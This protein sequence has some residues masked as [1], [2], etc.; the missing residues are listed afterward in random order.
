VE[1]Q[2]HAAV[3]DVDRTLSALEQAYRQRAGHRNLLGIGINP[4]YDFLRDDP[5]FREMI[6]RV[7]L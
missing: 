3:G 1:G 4:L 5:G 7:G 6:E 2:L